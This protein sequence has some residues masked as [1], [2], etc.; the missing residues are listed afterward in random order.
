[1]K[2]PYEILGVSQNATEDEIKRRYRELARK[3]HPDNC[4]DDAMR[5]YYAE[6]MKEINTAYDE[7]LSKRANPGQNGYQSSSSTDP[8]YQQIRRLLSENRIGEADRMLESVTYN[9]RRGEWLYLKGAVF[10]RSGRYLD[11][12]NMLEAACREDPNNREYQEA[13][14]TMKNAANNMRTG[15]YG[16]RQSNAG[17]SNCDICTT[18]LCAD[19]CCECMGGDLIRCC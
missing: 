9:E 3:Y 15:S 5:E 1:M 18:L 11:A 8:F 14:F 4:Q 19:C 6:K 16:Q 12:L 13:L 7:I 17:C 10:M 2:N